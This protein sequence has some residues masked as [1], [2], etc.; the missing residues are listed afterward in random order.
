MFER[1][2][3]LF[4]DEEEC[5]VAWT[6]LAAAQMQTGR[7]QP[8]VRDR[9]LALIE[10][11]GDLVYWREEPTFAKQR[12]Q[13]L[14]KLAEKLGGPQPAPKTLKRA[15]FRPSPLDVGDVVHVRNQIG[16]EENE[17][18]FV[19][20]DLMQWHNPPGT[21][22]VLAQFLWHGGPIPDVETLKTMPLIH[23]ELVG[24]DGDFWRELTGAK[25][26]G[27][28]PHLW[29][30]T[31]PTR[32]KY[33]FKHYGTVVTTGVLRPDAGDHLRDQSRGF[34]DGP[35]VSWGSWDSIAYFSGGEWY[36]RMVEA[37]KRV[38]GL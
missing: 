24:P 31:C 38:Y 18:L 19:V 1:F 28:V 11:G 36:A 25:Y 4:E 14:A 2:G 17:A 3:D 27:P 15:K 21:I 30:V 7:L 20:V 22:P 34:G 6:A 23:E 5:I 13:V 29:W 12:E 10:G 32:G 33:A 8:D 35:S 16:N 26:Q 9:T 37:T